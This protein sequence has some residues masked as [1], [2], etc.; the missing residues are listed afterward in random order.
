MPYSYA[1]TTASPGQNTVAVPFPYRAEADVSLEVDGVE[2]TAFTWSTA[3]L[4]SLTVPLVGGE[5][6]LVQRVTPAA[7]PVVTFAPGTITAKDLN[8][9]SLQLLYINQEAQDIANSA[10]SKDEALNAWNALTL[11]IINVGTPTDPT[12]AATKAYAD[13]TLAL[14]AANVALTNADVV[15][16]HADVVLTHADV[17]LTNADVVLTGLD[18]LLASQ[19]ADKAEDDPV[20]TGPNRFSAMHWAIK[21]EEAAGAFLPVADQINAASDETFLDTAM[22]V[23]RKADGSLIKRSWANIKTLITTLTNTLYPAIVG[24]TVDNRVVRWNGVAGQ[25]QDSLVTIDDAGRIYVGNGTLALP[26]IGFTADP[27]SGFW[28]DSDNS[29]R[30]V[31]GT[32]GIQSG[33]F[34]SGWTSTVA[35]PGATT[36]GVVA[37]AKVIANSGGGAQIDVT[38]GMSGSSMRLSRGVAVDGT[39]ASFH[40]ETAS[41]G[42]ISVTS[43]ATAYNTSSDYRLK[44]DVVP[45]VEFELDEADYWRLSENLLRLMLLRPVSHKWLVDPDIPA[46]H[47]FIA[48]EVQ[49]ITANAVSGK[50]DEVEDI[51][52][53]VIPE[54]TVPGKVLRKASRF[55][56]EKRGPAVVVP[57]EVTENIPQREAPTGSVWTKT[58]TRP[59]HQG[60]DTSFLLADAVASIQELTLL[61]IDLQ[62]KVATLEQ[63]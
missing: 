46:V 63:S 57:A 38:N 45:L 60:I 34:N 52:T 24:T 16:T 35:A 14:T 10:L 9:M 53:A 4:L 62:K 7:N 6:V 50:K 2:V 28:T 54:H 42:T 20:V 31:V 17:V 1:V 13:S 8:T 12:D 5:V 29:G 49:A 25:Q 21:A 15:L 18:V 27:D 39:I 32:Q 56:K 30:I 61:V 19:W 48:H 58:G 26:S 22:L 23:A 47:G 37:A 36:F 55:R 43:A 11:K 40:R 44:Y 3:S 51:G 59:V 33:W 41:V